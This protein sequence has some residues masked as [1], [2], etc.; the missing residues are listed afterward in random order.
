MRRCL[1]LAGAYNLVWGAFAILFPATIFEWSDAQPPNYPQLWQCIGMIVG[2][3][4]IGYLIAASDPLRHWPIVL[5]GLLGKILGPIGFAHAVLTGSF[6]AALAWTILTNDLIW[7]VP[8]GLIL[9]AAYRDYICEPRR[10]AAAPLADLLQATKLGSGESLAA[11]SWS[12]PVLLVFLRHLGCTFCREALADLQAARRQLESRGV[13][14]VLVHMG[15]PQAAVAALAKYGLSDLGTIA[16]PERTL[17][18]AFNLRRGSLRQLFGWKVW[19][20]GFVAGILRRHGVGPLAGDGFQMPG[21]FLIENGR[22]LRAFVHQT[23][24][25]RPDYPALAA[26]TPSTGADERAAAPAAAPVVAAV[27]RTAR[28]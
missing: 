5:V 20:R 11:A 15:D 16:D 7:W 18:A 12:G 6:P 13:R 14:I 25:D 2:V 27:D 22:V 9:H 24:A 26:C 3:Y 28:T 21:A 19:R 10:G 4:G 1:V 8:F 23:A 17:Y